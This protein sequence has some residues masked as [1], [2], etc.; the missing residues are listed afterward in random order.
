MRNVSAVAAEVRYVRFEG[1]VLD[2][3][4]LTYDTAISITPLAGNS[5]TLPPVLLD[6]YDLGGQTSGYL[7][8]QVSLYEADREK[9]GSEQ[10]FLDV[11]GDGFSTLR[12]WLRHADVGDLHRGRCSDWLCNWLYLAWCGRRADRR[13]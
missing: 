3:V 1:E 4:F 7:R 5:Q 6:F 11:S 10:V 9:L 13:A 12:I 2:M 8:G